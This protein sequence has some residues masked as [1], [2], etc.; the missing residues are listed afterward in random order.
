MG[1]PSSLDSRLVPEL[2]EEDGDGGDDE[3]TE[4]SLLVS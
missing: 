4:G 1:P 3:I 2:M